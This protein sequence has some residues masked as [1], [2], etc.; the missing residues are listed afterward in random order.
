MMLLARDR[1]RDAEAEAPETSCYLTYSSLRY[2][3]P[4][5]I[6]SSVEFPSSQK[7]LHNFKTP[8]TARR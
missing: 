7:W 1:I 5:F 6:K 2:C 8:R 3:F 4:K